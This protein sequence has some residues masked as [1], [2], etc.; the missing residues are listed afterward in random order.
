MFLGWTKSQAHV[1]D[2]HPLIIFQGITL[3]IIFIK[4]CNKT[5][6]FPSFQNCHFQNK[7]KCKFFY[8]IWKWVSLARQLNLYFGIRLCTQPHFL[9]KCLQLQT[10]P[11]TTHDTVVPT[12]A[13]VK[14]APMFLKKNLWNSKKLYMSSRFF[15]ISF[16]YFSWLTKCFKWCL[17]E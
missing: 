2:G 8:F 13:Y 9:V 15:V 16:H 7:A 11:K 12:K 14:I 10:Y 3:V 5:P 17:F 6:W 4:H 1:K